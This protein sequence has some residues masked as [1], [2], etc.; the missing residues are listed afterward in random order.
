MKYYRELVQR[1]I[2]FGFGDLF[3]NLKWEQV[4]KKYPNDSELLT[5]F[6]IHMLNT[7]ALFISSI[8][9]VL[10]L[11]YFFSTMHG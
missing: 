8:L 10:F 3:N 6:R 9:L 2:Q 11:M 5:R 7:G 1:R 4:L